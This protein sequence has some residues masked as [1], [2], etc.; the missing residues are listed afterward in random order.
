ME[1]D[2][3]TVGNLPLPKRLVE[4]IDS[5]RWPRTPDDERH[6]NVRSLVPKERIQ[7]FAPGEDRIYFVRPPFAT[8][9][10]RM[11]HGDRFWSRFGALEQI[12]PELAIFLG[13]FGIGSDSPILLDYRRDITTPAVIRLKLNSILGDAMPNGRRKLLGW[14]NSWLTCADSFDA[15][16]EMLGL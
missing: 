1:T 5:G 4:L 9:A 12:T 2:Y 7:S 8:V 3:K 11:S 10:T 6:Q 14:A 16:A 15:F 13:D